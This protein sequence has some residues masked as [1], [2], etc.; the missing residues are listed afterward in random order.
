MLQKSGAIN[1]RK[2]DRMDKERELIHAKQLEMGVIPRSNDAKTQRDS[3]LGRT[4]T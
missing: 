4:I 3:C 2:Y 1:T